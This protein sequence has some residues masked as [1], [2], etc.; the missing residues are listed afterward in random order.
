MTKCPYC[1]EAMEEGFITL[2][3]N[4]L[5]DISWSMKP[6]ILGLRSEKLTGWSVL[7]KNMEGLR[8]KTCRAV[9]FRY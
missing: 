4:S 3:T 9:S 8:C 7:A 5:A 1:G 2:T 6:S